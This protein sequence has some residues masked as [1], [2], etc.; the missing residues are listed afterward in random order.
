VLTLPVSQRP[1]AG[2]GSILLTACLLLPFA[3]CAGW[4]S[5]VENGYKVGPNYCPPDAPVSEQWIYGGHPALSESEPECDQW[6]T[7]FNDPVLP[8]LIETAYRQNPNLKAACWRI[9]EA[10]AQR[11]IAVGGLFPQTQN[12]QAS[13]H[14]RTSSETLRGQVIPQQFYDDWALGGTLAWELD[15]WGRY[16]RA[17][18]AADATLDASVESYHNV[19]VLLF[20]DVAFAYVQIRTLDQRLAYARQNLKLNKGIL[21]IAELRQAGP[22]TKLDVM[23]AKTAG[24]EL[25]A[26]IAV[27]K[28]ARRQNENRLCVLLGIPPQRLGGFLG[29]VEPIPQVPAQVAVGIPVD[30]LRRRPDIRQSERQIAAQCANIGIAVSELYPHL[31]IDGAIGVESSQVSQLFQSQSLAGRIGPSIQWNILH[32]GRIAGEIRLQ[33]S[34]FR[35]LIATY[36]Y[37][38]LR[39]YQEAEDAQV[40]YLQSMVEVKSLKAG[41][42]AAATSVD[43]AQQQ[44]SAGTSDYNRLFTVQQQ[45]TQSQDRLALA[46]GEVA[47][48]LVLLYKALGGGWQFDPECSSSPSPDQAFPAAEE[49]E[50]VPTPPASPR[51]TAP[52]DEEDAGSE[53]QTRATRSRANPKSTAAHRGAAATT[54]KVSATSDELRWPTD[55]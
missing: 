14:R 22:G 4:H 9:T 7:V 25:E 50:V 21:K 32:Y 2:S 44:Y 28:T 33:K 19:L 30:L 36:Q 26:A 39:A 42:K 52:S 54:R 47:Q 46:Q 16:R 34:R 38:V 23:Q 27:L 13:Y 41:A 1:W 48:N 5:Y 10:R 31:S 11:Q 45:L 49:G 20:S 35:E 6:W 55:P 53:E 24:S 12:L 18:E 8:R 15:F 29:G 51:D 43:L 3:G 40:A 17:V 37:T